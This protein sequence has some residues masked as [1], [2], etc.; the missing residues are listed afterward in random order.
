MWIM[1]NAQSMTWNMTRNIEK[2]GKREMLTVG[3]GKRCVNKNHGKCETYTVR[4]GIWRE[5]LKNVEN[6]KCT[7][8]DLDNSENTEIRGK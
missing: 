6:E 5:T 4:P 7:L 3:H 8:Y 1:R 2:C